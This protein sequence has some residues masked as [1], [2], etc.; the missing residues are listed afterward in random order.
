MGHIHHFID[1]V[2]ELF[3][4]K[5][6]FSEDDSESA[7]ISRPLELDTEAGQNL[8]RPDFRIDRILKFEPKGTLDKSP[9]FTVSKG[10]GFLSQSYIVAMHQSHFEF[11][12]KATSK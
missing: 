9:R 12:Q 2:E 1:G 5:Q 7:T 6:C 10:T 8:W 3:A 11:W 4:A